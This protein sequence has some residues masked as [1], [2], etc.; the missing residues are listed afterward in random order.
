MGSQAGD[1]AAVVSTSD[2]ATMCEVFKRFDTKNRG[3]ITRA[4]LATVLKS[5]DPGRWDE[6]SVNAIVDA[7]DINKDGRI[8]Y[9]EFVAWLSS[10]DKRV[11]SH[12][13][14]VRNFIKGAVEEPEHLKSALGNA[15]HRLIRQD[16][17]EHGGKAGA[18][19]FS[20]L[21]TMQPSELQVLLGQ[22]PHLR[23][24]VLRH[25][26]QQ[27]AVRIDRQRKATMPPRRAGSASELK[28]LDEN[29][30]IYGAGRC[31]M[32]QSG[33]ML[34]AGAPQDDRIAPVAEG[35]GP[36]NQPRAAASI[37]NEPRPSSRSGSRSGRFLPSDQHLSR[38]LRLLQC[39]GPADLGEDAEMKLKAMEV[40]IHR[41][42]SIARN[43]ADRERDPPGAEQQGPAP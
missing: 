10:G 22:P 6:A 25:A 20:L 23:D 34:E 43:N 3:V 31:S 19:A 21:E 1:G 26:I 32:P 39:A 42:R 38:A 35:H 33:T 12:D 14:M 13:R 16:Y 18:I 11:E 8:A 27:S 30:A 40:E 41:L 36:D 2:E 9:P 5:L 28:A 17:P 37:S 15:L 4:E 7:A 24:Q 29:S